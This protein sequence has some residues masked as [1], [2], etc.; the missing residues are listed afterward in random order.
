MTDFSAALRD[1]HVALLG[2]SGLGKSF[3][4]Q[5]L[6]RMLIRRGTDGV[7]FVDPHSESAD[8]IYAWLANPLNGISDRTVHLIKP[9]SAYSIGINPL[10]TRGDTSPEAC[11]AAAQLLTS[12]VEAR[13]GQ[14]AEETP[15][16][17]K[18]IYLAAF[19]CV[20]KGLSVAEVLEIL[21]LGS[22]LRNALLSDF[23]EGLIKTELDDLSTLADKQP[24]RFIEYCESTKSRFVRVLG[25]PHLRRLLTQRTNLDAL[26]VMNGREIVIA[27]L[28]GLSPSDASFVGTLLTSIYGAA[29]RKRPPMRSAPMRLII[30]EAESMITTDTA[31]MLDQTRKWGLFVVLSVQR[32]GQLRAKGDFILDAVLTNCAVKISF[33]L[34]EPESARFMAEVMF[35]GHVKL[36]EWKPGSERPVA[37]GQDVRTTRSR[38]TTDIE[39]TTEADGVISAR[40]ASASRGR[41]SFSSR[42][43]SAGASTSRGANLQLSPDT[44]VLMAGPTPG[45]AAGMLA[46]PGLVG[47]QASASESRNTLENEQAGE[48]L[49][50][51]EIEGETSG[52]THISGR[53]RGTASTEGENECFVTRYQWLP[54]QSYTLEEQWHRLTGL[55]I[56]LPKRQCLVK[57]GP[58]APFFTRTRDLA[59]PFRSATFKAEI[60][61][62]FD[63]AVARKSRYMRPTAEVD[64]ELSEKLRKLVPHPVAEPDPA[65]RDPLPAIDA[66]A[67]MTA[68]PKPARAKRGGKPTLVVDNPPP[69]G[70]AES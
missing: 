16:L 5:H 62:L 14:S 69:D 38:S 63:A 66:L 17:S 11:H 2:G 51:A 65:R 54:S 21:S 57:I 49:I 22:P 32:L 4:L 42:G 44:M 31:R 8:A 58:A 15:R 3:L 28:G 12:V 9:E 67:G 20:Y 64:A 24:A 26:E 39:T 1:N 27:S 48:S 47:Q 40:V 34:P 13:F 68:A 23:P 46:N 52:E 29:A 25:S 30:D 35:T 7:T 50:E 55:L 59:P 6:T 10:D 60:L 70:E 36:A 33:G 43:Q 45:A 37:V 18:L 53:A 61:P 41:G 19:V 56:N